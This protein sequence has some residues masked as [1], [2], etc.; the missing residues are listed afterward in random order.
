MLSS[1]LS[2]LFTDETLWS[3]LVCSSTS[4]MNTSLQG[5]TKLYHAGNFCM[6]IFE[7]CYTI[8]T[9]L[10][11]G[12]LAYMYGTFSGVLSL[13]KCTVHFFCLS[14]L[15]LL[16][17]FSGIKKKCT[18]TFFLSHLKM[19]NAHFQVQRGKCTCTFYHI[20]HIIEDFRDFWNKAA[21]H[22]PPPPTKDMFY[23]VLQWWKSGFNN[24]TL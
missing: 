8:P 17:I 5:E 13:K 6:S 18:C 19:Y 15:D 9:P 7:K 11:G 23:K 3:D 4:F 20:L 1:T 2:T 21:P 10:M 12:D 14:P 24:C 16:Y 22:T